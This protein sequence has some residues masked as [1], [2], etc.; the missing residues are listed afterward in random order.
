MNSLTAEEL[1]KFLMTL[2]E[3]TRIQVPGKFRPQFICESDLTYTTNFN[4]EH[5]LLIG[6]RVDIN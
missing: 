2:P 1:I 6:T 4:D 3:D 5:Y